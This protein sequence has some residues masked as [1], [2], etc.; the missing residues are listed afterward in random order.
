MD[1][2]LIVRMSDRSKERFSRK[3]RGLKAPIGINFGLIVGIGIG[4]VGANQA[5][6]DPAISLAIGVGFGIVFGA[7]FGRFFKPLRRYERTGSNYTYEGMPF[8]AEEED[9]DSETAEGQAKEPS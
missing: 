7:L 3:R 4:A 9:S 8:A 1:D 6:A 5:G 2:L